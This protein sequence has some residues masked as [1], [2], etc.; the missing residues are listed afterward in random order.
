MQPNQ[1]VAPLLH[2]QMVAEQLER[3]EQHVVAVRHHVAPVLAPGPIVGRLQQPEVAR[4]GVAAD[5]E[6]PAVV[7]DLI[8]VPPLPRQED[9]EIAAGP[10]RLGVAVLGRE[11]MVRADQDV[12]LRAALPDAR[13]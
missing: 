6:A 1:A 9:R 10:I 7:I 11:R 3:L 5:I 8:L 13:N 4:P 12:A 2:D